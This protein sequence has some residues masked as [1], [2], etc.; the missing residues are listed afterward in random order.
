[1][2]K[3]S[4]LPLYVIQK[5]EPLMEKLNV[6]KIAR[7]PTGFLTAY[8]NGSIN[9]EWIT[10]RNAF[11]ARHLAQYNKKPTLRRGLAIIAWAHMPDKLPI[12]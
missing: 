5:Y 7:S 11:L 10:K 12:K 6:S 2:S 1:M 8:K 3:Y 9:S 4:W